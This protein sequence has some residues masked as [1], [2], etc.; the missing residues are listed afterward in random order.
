MQAVH[1][2]ESTCTTGELKGNTHI[3]FPQHRK[4]NPIVQLAKLLD[5]GIRPGILPAKLI[6]GET[7]DLKVFAVRRLER[8]VE[9]LQPFELWREA[10]FGG[11]VD[12]EDDFAAELREVVGLFAL[13][14][15]ED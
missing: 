14:G 10:A 3:D 2:R 5:L 4:A 7:Q 13:C 15:E 1:A 11:C 9:F 6:A 8:L 12:D